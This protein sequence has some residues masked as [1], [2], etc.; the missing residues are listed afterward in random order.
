M[1]I[2]QGNFLIFKNLPQASRTILDCLE[3]RPLLEIFTDGFTSATADP[4]SRTLK[5]SGSKFL[6]LFKDIFF[7]NSSIKVFGGNVH[8]LNCIQK[9]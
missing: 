9:K 6:I 2:A 3:D 1:A 7:Q 5:S 8:V 4:A